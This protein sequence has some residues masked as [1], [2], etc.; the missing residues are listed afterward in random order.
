MYVVIAYFS[1]AVRNS[2]SSFLIISMFSFWRY[3]IA[4]LFA[5]SAARLYP[6]V[7]FIVFPVSNIV[8]NV[9][10]GVSLIR[11][12]TFSPVFLFFAFIAYS[13]FIF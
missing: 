2:F 12:F 5:S 7:P 1:V 4:I 11:H 6:S 13:M 10:Q 9:S 8:L 3:H